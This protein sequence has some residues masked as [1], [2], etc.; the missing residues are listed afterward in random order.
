MNVDEIDS[1][2]IALQILERH[3]YEDAAECLRDALVSEFA[4]A[5]DTL[6]GE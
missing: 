1:V 3:G 6:H 5:A 4:K 2:K